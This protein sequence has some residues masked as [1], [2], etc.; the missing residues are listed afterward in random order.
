MASDVVIVGAGPN[1]LAAA[2]A[3]ADAGLE[4]GVVEQRELA[5]GGARTE[6]LT[7]PGFSHDVCSAV[8]PLGIASPFLRTLSLEDHGLAWI[9]P[10][11]PLVHVMADG[12]AIPLLR[13]LEETAA[14]LG[15]DAGEYR[16]LFSPFVE[17]FDEL[18][19]MILGPLRL[20]SSPL[21]MARFGI[22]GLGSASGMIHRRFSGRGLRAL[23]AGIAVH[24]ML[25]LDRMATAAFT[26]VL[27][28]SAHAAGW[29][30]AR[31]GSR[32]IVD[33]ML[34]RLRERGV[35]VETG[36]FVRQLDDLPGA[37]AYVFDV[38]PR[39]LL[40]IA[41]N[42]LPSSYRRRLG[43]Y[44]YGAGVCKVDWALREPIPWLDADCATSAT[45]HLSGT[46]EQVAATE[47]AVHAGELPERPFVILVQPTLFDST[48]AP[49]GMHTAWAYCHVPHGCTVDVSLHIEAEVERAAP[50]FHDLVLARSVK[51]AADMERYNPNYVGGDINGGL[52]SLAQLFFRPVARLDPYSTPNP[53]IF[54]CSSSTP[55]GGGVHGMCGYWAARSVL[56]RAFGRTMP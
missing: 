31:G 12:G 37:R 40:S 3:L 50:G 38:T 15:A 13:S 52:A 8:H 27:A 44:R 10:P 43:R 53:S 18:M 49:D 19:K 45:V 39:Q 47:A 35:T 34:A 36:R 46:L 48:R 17:R 9:Q 5:G 4:V 42:H 21:L 20:P 7:L 33:A 32:S 28:A 16:H 14:G 55:P 26:M 24:A 51:T 6:A 30:I 22:T 1:G 54:L 41:G 2:I 29:P 11:C 25:P 56:R 23:M